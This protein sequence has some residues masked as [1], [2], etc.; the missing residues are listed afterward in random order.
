MERIPNESVNQGVTSEI[1][2]SEEEEI[3]LRAEQL[4][5]DLLIERIN[6]RR[7]SERSRR[8]LL[9][10]EYQLEIEEHIR[11]FLAG[12]DRPFRSRVT[13]KTF[14]KFVGPPGSNTVFC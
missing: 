1:Y 5:Q 2:Q 4:T 9:N 10:L 3:F 8:S 11:E 14:R 13:V 7:L 6:Q 12:M